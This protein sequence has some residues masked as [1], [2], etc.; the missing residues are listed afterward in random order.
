MPYLPRKQLNILVVSLVAITVVSLGISALD[1]FLNV[2]AHLLVDY[3]CFDIIWIP[4]SVTLLFSKCLFIFVVL[5][6]ISEFHYKILFLLKAANH[7]FQ[8]QHP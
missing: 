7:N 5:N 4:Y 3:H 8:T 6:H 1:L 2:L